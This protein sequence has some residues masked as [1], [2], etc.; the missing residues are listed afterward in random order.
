M[1]TSME[2]R[3]FVM[4]QEECAKELGVAIGTVRHFLAC[5]C[6]PGKMISGSWVIDRTRLYDTRAGLKY[7]VKPSKTFKHVALSTEEAA[8][9]TGL[10]VRTIRDQLSSGRLAGKY[11]SGVWVIDGY[12]LPFTR[13]RRS[14]RLPR[15]R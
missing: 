11:T 8:Q 10:S 4:T 14:P 15:D 5:G 9:R 6:L 3:R 7:R 13:G 1:R 2:F 12:R